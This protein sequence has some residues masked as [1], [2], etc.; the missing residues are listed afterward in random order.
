MGKVTQAKMRFQEI[1]FKGKKYLLISDNESEGAIATKQ[2]FENGLPS[3]AHLKQG[4]V[5]RFNEKIGTVSDITFTG[6]WI[7]V[8]PK[9]GP[10]ETMLNFMDVW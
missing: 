2:Q 1:R 10:M 8:S 9:V 5:H 3:Y 4:N 7:A 6:N